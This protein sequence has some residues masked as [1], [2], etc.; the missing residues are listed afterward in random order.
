MSFCKRKINWDSETGAATGKNNS[1]PCFD[2]QTKFNS[3]NLE[4]DLTVKKRSSLVYKSTDI[5]GKTAKKRKL[6]DEDFVNKFINPEG[7]FWFLHVK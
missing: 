1:D 2:K 6:D 4:A 5:S 7:N 3:Y